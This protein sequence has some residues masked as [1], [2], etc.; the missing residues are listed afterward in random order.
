MGEPAAITRTGVGV[1]VGGRMAVG[2]PPD[3]EAK[4]SHET[5]HAGSGVGASDGPTGD[6]PTGTVALGPGP[7]GVAVRGGAAVLTV[8]VGVMVAG[9][10]V[11]SSAVAVGVLVA[12][13]VGMG[14]AVAVDVAVAVAVGVALDAGVDAAVP[15]C[16]RAD[17]GTWRLTRASTRRG[18]HRA[19]APWIKGCRC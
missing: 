17:V 9:R 3:N 13:R 18:C 10:I 8:A 11:D 6:G 2:A 19:A 16:A 14:V 4:A 1:V 5:L 15:F 7:S 12:V